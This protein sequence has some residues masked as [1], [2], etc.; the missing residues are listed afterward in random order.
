[1]FLIRARGHGNVRATHET[2]LEITR[3]DFLTPR[4]DCIVAIS[5]NKGLVDLD[6]RIKK[7]LNSGGRIVIEISCSSM[8]ERIIGYGDPRLTFKSEE[9][10]VI[11]KSDFVCDRTLCI[12]A[13]KSAAD[14]SREL[15]KKIRTGAD[16]FIY[17][18][19]V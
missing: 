2:A 18:D 17:V 1:M 14:L 11:R 8:K 19:V 16:V 4:G 13:D 12:R 5:A 15:V 9:S 7:H 3:E 6:N 10:I